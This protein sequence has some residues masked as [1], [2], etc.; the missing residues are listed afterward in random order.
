MGPDSEIFLLGAYLQESFEKGLKNKKD[1][2]HPLGRAAA[3][4]VPNLIV[5]LHPPVRSD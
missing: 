2:L 5:F 3:A 1:G 4:V